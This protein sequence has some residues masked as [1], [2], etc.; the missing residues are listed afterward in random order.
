MEIG[1]KFL[2]TSD[3][4]Q[5]FS[6]HFFFR[7]LVF[8]LNSRKSAKSNKVEL[9][10]GVLEKRFYHLKATLDDYFFAEK[11]EAF[12][13]EL[14]GTVEKLIWRLKNQ[15]ES[16]CFTKIMLDPS[17]GEKRLG[18]VV[19]FTTQ[20][21][22]AFLGKEQ[23]QEAIIHTMKG[24]QLIEETFYDGKKGDDQVQSF[25]FEIQKSN[26]EPFRDVEIKAIEENF[27]FD[28][29][30]RVTLF[31]Y[32]MF[33]PRNEEEVMRNML[34]LAREIKFVKDLPQVI[35]QFRNQTQQ[36]LVFDFI[37][38]KVR[39]DDDENLPDRFMKDQGE[40]VYRFE[41]IREV[42]DVRKKTIK[43]AYLFQVDVDI[44]NF[45]RRD[46]SVDLSRARQ[47]ILENLKEKLG[48][49]RDFNGGIL[50]KEK[51]L[52]GKTRFEILREK[53]LNEHLLENLFYSIQPYVIRTLVDP[54]LISELYLL[55]DQ[56]G[57]E[58]SNLQ[59]KDKKEGVVGVMRSTDNSKCLELRACLEAE[60]HQGYDLGSLLYSNR[61]GFFLG[62][63]FLSQDKNQR[64]KFL[65][66]VTQ[67]SERIFQ[68]AR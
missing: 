40:I 48:A 58:E 51:E 31:S 33:L 4:N 38:C 42:G 53:S 52:L 65:L 23:I 18:I 10:P 5:S 57:V 61:D 25:Y 68:K 56:G 13:K 67:L 41:R 43:D 16:N 28:L 6:H 34:Q 55:I 59:F 63:I 44:K 7:P 49:L 14:I 30:D 45:L 21:Q 26:R 36:K 3:A 62:L 15:R 60:F 37:M 19:A 24:A 8:F 12:L 20:N 32:P 50:S 54:S 2:G 47:A 1:S 46:L 39:S 27:S 35:I 29:M 11:S 22:H 64:D 9:S 66:Q 17:F